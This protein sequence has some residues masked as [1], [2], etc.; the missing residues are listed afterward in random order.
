MSTL[1]TQENL[2]QSLIKKYW[3]DS[4]SKNKKSY[5]K[6][7]YE[8]M[9][10]YLPLLEEENLELIDYKLEWLKNK[11]FQI[12]CKTCW[13]IYIDRLVKNWI[14]S[15]CK[16]CFPK[17]ETKAENELFLFLSEYIDKKEII[18]NDRKLLKPLELDLLIKKEFFAI[19][20][21]W[22]FY[23]SFWKNNKDHLKLK[24]I[25]NNI[26]LE[27]KNK[28][29]HYLKTEN[30]KNN[31][32]ELFHI[33]DLEWDNKQKRLIWKDILRKKIWIFDIVENDSIQIEKV[34]IKN[35]KEFNSK[36]S[37]SQY[38]IN[39]NTISIWLFKNWIQYQQI[40]YEENS[41]LI[42]IKTFCNKIWFN[43]L[44]KNLFDYLIKIW[45]DIHLK[46]DKR[47]ENWNNFKKIWFESN[48]F[49]S[50]TFFYYKWRKMFEFEKF[51]ETEEELLNNGYRKYWNCWYEKL[52]YKK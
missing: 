1:Q 50:P 44:W 5:E 41:M 2:K 27:E 36:N 15:R 31:W 16:V 38:K 9:Q 51:D 47:Y 20:Y 28:N 10:K 29:Y 32:I 21:D 6:F 45:K 46:I 48:W 43:F 7:N 22:L 3:V 17:N 37:L 13:N 12:K 14:V 8:K 18:K 49:E 34:L 23:H 24:Y 33:L 40:C 42:E 4:V 25:H 30:C 39:E 35:A 11:N 19:E 26:H 52:I